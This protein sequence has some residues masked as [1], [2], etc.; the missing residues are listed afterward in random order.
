MKKKSRTGT[1]PPLRST[2][3]AQAPSRKPV[4]WFRGLQNPKTLVGPEARRAGEYSDSALSPR[5]LARGH[6]P[7]RPIRLIRP[8]THVVEVGPAQKSGMPVQ[9]RGNSLS[10]VPQ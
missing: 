10:G 6:A 7:I 4:P 9:M 1:A 2:V 5:F 8:A 3:P